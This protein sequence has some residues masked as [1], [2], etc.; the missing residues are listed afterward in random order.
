MALF[1]TPPFTP[2]YLQFGLDGFFNDFFDNF[3]L[4]LNGVVNASLL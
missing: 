3:L 1:F 4:T 2:D